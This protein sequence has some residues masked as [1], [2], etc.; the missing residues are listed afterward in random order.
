MKTKNYICSKTLLNEK[1]QV[2]DDTWRPGGN[3]TSW[4]CQSFDQFLKSEDN[5]LESSM[6]CSE[7]ANLVPFVKQARADILEATNKDRE[8]NKNKEQDKKS[9]MNRFM[10][11]Y[12]DI[13]KNR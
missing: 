1:Y 13:L 4:G 11:Q 12:S 6:K 3:S 5:H 10:Q 8:N 9:K 7:C 2:G